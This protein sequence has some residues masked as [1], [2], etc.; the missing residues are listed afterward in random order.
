M[1][2]SP[3]WTTVLSRGAFKDIYIW[4]PA[5]RGFEL[6]DRGGAWGISVFKKLLDD[7]NLQPG[8]PA[9]SSKAENLSLPGLE[10]RFCHLPAM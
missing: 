10:S 6:A 4:T 5:L 9:K 2:L 8:L 1:A 3:W 7:F